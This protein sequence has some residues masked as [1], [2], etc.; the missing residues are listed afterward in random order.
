MHSGPSREKR[1]PG[2][3]PIRRG[4][5]EHWPSMSAN[6]RSFY[7]WLHLSAYWQDGPKR[8]AVEA[9]FE[10]MARANGWSLKVLRGAIEELEAKP[11]VEVDRAANQHELTRIKILKYDREESE[12]APSLQGSSSEVGTSLAPSLAPSLQGSSE[13]RSKPAEPQ[14]LNGLHAPKKVKKLRSKEKVSHDGLTDGLSLHGGIW[15]SSELN[16]TSLPKKFRGFV[17]LVEENEPIDAQEIF[18]DWGQTILDLCGRRGI[19]YP[20]VFL[21]RVKDAERKASGGVFGAEP[22]EISRISGHRGVREEL[23]R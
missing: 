16:L 3:A 18:A 5:L 13:G 2:F 19:R 6:A 15:A 12:S 17:D 14:N 23:M 1:N 7:V 22:D 21:R 4:L 9:S 20:K 11:Y 8:G 10:D